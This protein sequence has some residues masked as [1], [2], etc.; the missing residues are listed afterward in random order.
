MCCQPTLCQSKAVKALIVTPHKAETEAERL[1]ARL[2][3]TKGWPAKNERI[4]DDVYN[5][6]IKQG[7][8]ALPCLVNRIADT[9]KMRDPRPDPLYLNFRVGDAA[10][11]LAHQIANVPLEQMLP[12][13]VQTRW[14]EEGVYA[15]FRYVEKAAN[16]KV[17]QNKWKIWLKENLSI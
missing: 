14:K 17:L 13:N 1:C 2:S 11:F 5:G 7:K 10:F 8:A 15:Y 16:R 4:N 12:A 6:L 9:T 3:E